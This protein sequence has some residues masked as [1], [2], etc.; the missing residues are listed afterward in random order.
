MKNLYLED[1]RESFAKLDFWFKSRLSEFQ[2]RS[3]LVVNE[4]FEML[5]N[6]ELSQKAGF[7]KDS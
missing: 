2:K 5:S 7:S 6:E 4:A 3:L 1:I